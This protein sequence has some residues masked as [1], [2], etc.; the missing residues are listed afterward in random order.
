MAVGI[1]HEERLDACPS[2]EKTNTWLILRI[3]IESPG[4]A[5]R[6]LE[7][8]SGDL[9]S[10][11]SGM[12]SVG[13]DGRMWLTLVAVSMAASSLAAAETV[14]SQPAPASLQRTAYSLDSPAQWL[15]YEGKSDAWYTATES[16]RRLLD[17]LDIGQPLVNRHLPHIRRY[18]AMLGRVSEFD[19]K[20]VTAP[21]FLQNMLEDLSAGKQP[22]VRY[23]GIGMAFPYWSETMQRI[24]AIWTHV[25]PD[26][27][28]TKGYQVFMYYK[29]GGG[30]HNKNGRAAGGYR[31]TVEVANQTDTFHC[32][33]SLNIQI[34]GRMGGHIEL[35]EAM[36]ALCREFS[37]DRDRVFLTGWS[38]GGF[39]AVWL[40]SHYPH[41]VTGIAP[42]CGNWQ[43]ANVEYLGLTNLPTLNVDGWFDGGY[44][45]ISFARWQMLRSDK[46]DTAC[47][48]GQHGHSYQPYEDVDEFKYILDWAKK[49]RR[50]L[51][52]KRVRYATWNLAWHQAYWGSIERMIDPLLAC[53]IDLEVKPDNRI[54]GRTWNVA[55]L[56]LS[57]CNALVDMSRPITVIINGREVYAGPARAELDVK[58]AERP[59][60]PFVKDAAMSD[61][62]AA[63]TVGSS[64]DTN[65]FLAIP[66]RRW[67]SVRPTGLA[68]TTTTLL[69]RWWPENAKA[70]SDVTDQDLAECNLIL[71]GGSE[72]NQL[73]ARMADRLPVKFENGRFSVG[74]A[75]YD[76]PTHCVTFLHPNPLNPK[77]YALV[78]ACNDPA[79]FAA[80]GFFEMTGESIWKFRRGDAVISGIPAEPIQ[81]GVAVRS[82]RY[83]QRHVMFGA[84]WC[85]DE[86]PPLGVA[87]AAFDYLQLL[88]LRADALREATDVDVGIIWE[89]TPGWNR[90]QDGMPSGP[91]TFQALATQDVCPE[92]VCV[93]EM[94]GED[95]LRERSRPAAWSLLTDRRQPAYVAGKTLAVS[96]IVPEKTYRVA[97]GFR[98]IPHMGPTPRKC[99]GF[100]AGPL[101]RSSWP[102][103][104]TPC[105]LGTSPGH[106][107]RSW[108]PSLSTSASIRKSRRVLRALA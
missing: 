60:A 76:R 17:T 105:Q 49:Y 38:D 82:S 35:T 7:T 108:K 45:N 56:K 2:A 93:G 27:D 86:R 9:G 12:I 55:E 64:Y 79:A 11:E 73:T 4:D 29:C 80:N 15:S 8:N 65:G 59:K 94:T 1:L 36:D 84:D 46:A 68:E 88:R 41:L 20:T 97:M 99:P 62:I 70:D 104:A 96:D 18:A 91:V 75:V 77:K 63:V 69:A 32:W 72:M 102:T 50:D 71:Y 95:L 26:Y 16:C 54:D 98:G 53:Q 66:D 3:A 19:W 22:H 58:M 5:G 83:L 31:P 52:P 13:K 39:T 67:I 10:R 78:Y 47:I 100:S 40:A 89:H 74:S 37:V 23:A 85:P 87:T 81:W 6:Q 61:E 107:Y 106:R 92:Q 30:I 28:P 42:S 24:E 21:E 51:H 14:W 103:K 101:R 48:W 34:K 90:W 44:N 25:P 57:L 33:S 43:Y